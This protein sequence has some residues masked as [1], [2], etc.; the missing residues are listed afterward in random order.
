MGVIGILSR[1]SRFATGRGRTPTTPLALNYVLATIA[2]IGATLAWGR[3]ADLFGE[4]HV[5]PAYFLI[6]L[7]VSVFLGLGP[8][9][10][11][12][13]LSALAAAYYFA[14]PIHSF[15]VT[16]ADDAWRLCAFISVGIMVNLVTEG[17]RRAQIAATAAEQSLAEFRLHSTE[18]RL[19]LAVE[20]AGIGVF[21]WSPVTGAISLDE[22]ACAH[23][24]LK[25][26]TSFSYD[27]FLDAVHVDDRA[28]VRAALKDALDPQ[29]AGRF[30]AEFRVV[31]VEDDVE[32]WI[33]G[34]GQAEFCED[35]AT[36]F[37]GASIDRTRRKVAERRL[38]ESEAFNRA[39]I[40][41]GPDCVKVLDS[42]GR[43]LVINEV[44]RKMLGI[45]DAK[46]VYGEEWS[47]FWPNDTRQ[48]VLD[49]M[50]TALSGEKARFRESCA[51]ADGSMQWWDMI[52]TPMRDSDGNVVRVLAVSR[53]VTESQRIEARL[54]ADVD[55]LTRMHALS[56]RLLDDGGLQPL[57]Q[58]IME[59]AVALMGAE[60]GTLQLLEN[61]ALRVAAHH[62]HKRSFLESFTAEQ[63]QSVGC[64]ES[65]GIGQR[66]VISDVEKSSELAGTPELRKLRKAGVR[67]MQSTPML[68]RSGEAIGVLTTHW[69]TPHAPDEHDLF[70]LELLIRQATDLIE[71]FRAREALR[72]ADRRKDEFLATL[73]HELRNPMAPISNGLQLLKRV[74]AN[75]AAAERILP[76][77]ERQVSQLVRLIDE[78]LDISR[79]NSGRIE[80][81]KER[82]D[83]AE[84]LRHAIDTSEPHIRAAAQRLSFDP[85][86]RPL[87]LEADPLR[88]TQVFTN[89]LNNASKFTDLG[90]EIRISAQGVGGDA[91]VSVLD[92]GVG[93][94]REMLPK[95]FEPFTQA[96]GASERAKGGLGIGLTLAQRLVELHGGRIQARSEGLGS[97]S[98]FIVRLPL[99]PDVTDRVPPKPAIARAPGAQRRILVIDDDADVA[100]SLVMLLS[101]YP[102]AARAAFSG[103]EGLAV[104]EAFRPDLVFL[105]IGMPDMDGLET[106]R[107]IRQAPEG[108][109][110]RLIALTGWGCEEDRRRSHEAGFDEHLVKPL[111]PERLEEALVLV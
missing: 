28:A 30:A 52:L 99:A 109:D 15:A 47:S 29:G 11:F 107:R 5:S 32:R 93:I 74:G 21:E 55:A 105:D 36:R 80:L 65:L 73:A 87:F 78:L 13:F 60:Q 10:I 85:P 50:Q 66:I 24:G 26:P 95:V 35:R 84:I 106:A 46:A 75:A 18:L 58:E 90:G 16:S 102:V 57:L 67:A 20:S 43:L 76:M 69:S 44:G 83:L 111:T 49:A 68:S 33:A 72:A 82:C 6:M 19:R 103:A 9:L 104:L 34:T 22:T 3:L 45:G 59:T 31:G 17:G 27:Q 100:N 56:A 110:V 62:D 77:M 54:G 97:G 12:V 23:W 92:S 1:W 25:A 38:R 91:A 40:E 96:D 51:L 14:E 64:V 70:R 53:D 71:N 8:G 4:M 41:S 61:G 2:A 42:A 101:S 81:R 94:S 39:I 98:E 108:R 63:L 7:P 79:L 86:Q 37:V 48:K 88:L 89:L